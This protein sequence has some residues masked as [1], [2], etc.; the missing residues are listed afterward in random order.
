MPSGFQ[1]DLD[2]LQPGFYRVVLTLNGGAASYPSAPSNTTTASGGVYPQNWDAFVTLPTAQSYSNSLS[3]GNL[4]WQAIVEEVCKVA[5]AQILDLVVTSG[6]T[7]VANNQPTQ[8]AFTVKYD[9]DAFVL[10]A[11]QAI[12]LKVNSANTSFTGYDN[13]TTITTT[14]RAIRQQ[15]TTG[16]IRGSTTGYSRSWRVYNVSGNQDMQQTVT[17][18]QPDIPASVFADVAVTQI[19][20]TTLV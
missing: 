19:S 13:S 7:T 8:V 5:D 16:L 11:V 12:M 6:D 9:R 18:T 4:R 17:I 3:Q 2:Q 15:V 1:Q 20:G 14:A 10:P